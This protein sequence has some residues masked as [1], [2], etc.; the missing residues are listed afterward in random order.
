MRKLIGAVLVMM[1]LYSGYWFI[2]SSGALAGARAALDQIR[3]TGQGNYAGVSLAGFPSRFDITIDR[4]ELASADG[5]LHWAAPFLQVLALSYQ[6]N[7]VIVVWPHEQQLTA[8]GAPLSFRSKDTRADAAVAATPDLPLDH[9]T[10]VSS[11]PALV[12]PRGW[13]ASADDLRLAMRLSAAPANAHQIGL[14]LDKLRVTGIALPAPYDSGAADVLA[15]ATV[16]FDRPLDRHA[17]DPRITSIALRSARLTWGPTVLDASGDLTVTPDG[18]PEGRLTIT[19]NGWRDALHLL[20]QLGLVRAE[21]A[22]TM[23][24]MLASLEKVSPQPGTLDIP[25]SFAAGMMS[26]GPLPLGPAPRL[27]G[28]SQ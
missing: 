20:T 22:P 24:N 12:S 28:Y 8:W 7:K 13:S 15:D 5:T 25:L 19:A 4:P 1:A 18:T 21:I 2:G 16:G 6:P 9:V 27:P 11:E 10:L 14:A 17:Q 26:I 23:E 3:A